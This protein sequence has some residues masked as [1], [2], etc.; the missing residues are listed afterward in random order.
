MLTLCVA[1]RSIAPQERRTIES[2]PRHKRTM[3]AYEFQFDLELQNQSV[4]SEP[5]AAGGLSR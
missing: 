2:L 5:A 1:A 3:I 4:H